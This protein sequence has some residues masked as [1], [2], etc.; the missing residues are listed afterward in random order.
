M[1]FKDQHISGTAQLLRTT[2][3]KKKKQASR[4]QL[5]F[6]TRTSYLFEQAPTNSRFQFENELLNAS[7]KWMNKYITVDTDSF[8]V[9]VIHRIT[10]LGHSSRILRKVLPG[11]LQDP[12]IPLG[13]PPTAP[14][15]GARSQPSRPRWSASLAKLRGRDPRRWNDTDSRLNIYRILEHGCV[16]FFYATKLLFIIG[17][18]S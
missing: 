18:Y 9:V 3:S 4:V 17:V 13:S 5:H 8:F 6:I 2:H 14:R 7:S 15:R 10:E 12:S 11:Q 1:H 16:F